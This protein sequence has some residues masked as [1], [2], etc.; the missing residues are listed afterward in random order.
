MRS[1]RRSG[2]MAFLICAIDLVFVARRTVP[3]SIAIIKR[4]DSRGQSVLQ[5]ARLGASNSHVMGQ[6]S[7]DTIERRVVIQDDCAINRADWAINYRCRS[8]RIEA[9]RTKL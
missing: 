1:K 3:P 6:T 4:I 2:M 9:E 7:R 8:N 5:I